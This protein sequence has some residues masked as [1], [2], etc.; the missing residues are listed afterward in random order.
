ML[1]IAAIR[2]LRITAVRIFTRA[3][4]EFVFLQKIIYI[5]INNIIINTLKK[6]CVGEKYIPSTKTMLCISII[7]SNPP[8]WPAVR[9]CSP[10][11]V[12]VAIPL[13]PSY[14]PDPWMC[15]DRFC[16]L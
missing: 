13:T 6:K 4:S 10:K 8:D 15:P 12:P 5:I 9:C 2:G 16:S 14:A 1:T 3:L 7:Q 11:P